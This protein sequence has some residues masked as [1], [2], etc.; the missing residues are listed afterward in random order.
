MPL[1][2]FLGAAIGATVIIAV[3]SIAWPRLSADPRPEMLTKVREVVIETPPGR[4]FSEVLGVTDETGVTPVSVSTIITTGTNAAVDMVTKST[5]KA[6]TEKILETLGSQFET[7]SEEEKAS[8]RA[9]I[10]APVE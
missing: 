2:Q 10:C 1:F 5:Q 4:S 8:F 3:I 6:V 9:K 7:L